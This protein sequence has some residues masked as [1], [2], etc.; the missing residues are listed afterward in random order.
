MTYLVTFT[1]ADMEL[2]L[3]ALRYMGGSMLMG[4]SAARAEEMADSLEAL[5]RRQEAATK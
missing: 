5:M 4:A 2:L 1:E 3:R